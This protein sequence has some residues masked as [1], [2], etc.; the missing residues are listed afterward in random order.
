MA[1]NQ[2]VSEWTDQNNVIEWFYLQYPKELII[3]IPNDLIRSPLQGVFNRRNGL[4]AGVPDL[5]V[6][7]IRCSFGAMFLEMK[8]AKAVGKR[9]GYISE[10]QQK[11]MELLR[12]KGY[13]CVVAYG[14]EDA[15]NAIKSY[16]DEN[17]GGFSNASR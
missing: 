5:L 1:L 10:N 7:A 17:V 11:I 16:M 9:R 8:R 12:A 13:H 6:A 2:R 14:F 4:V 3:K 15:A